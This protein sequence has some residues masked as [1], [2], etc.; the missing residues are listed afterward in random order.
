[1][2]TATRLPTEAKLL[3]ALRAGPASANDLAQTAGVNRKTVANRLRELRDQVQRLDDG[4]WQLATPGAVPIAHDPG[5]A[6]VRAAPEV[7]PPSAPAWEQRLTRLFDATGP[8]LARVLPLT[9]ALEAAAAAVDR[10][11]AHHAAL[12]DEIGVM[13]TE[14]AALEARHTRMARAGASDADLDVID[15]ALAGLSVRAGRRIAALP[16]AIRAHGAA[17]LAFC[18]TLRD[19]MT[20]VTDHCKERLRPTDEAW[21]HVSRRAAALA[22]APAHP[23]TRQRLS[24]DQQELATLRTVR[25][26]DVAAIDVLDAAWWMLP[27]HVQSATHLATLP[28]SAVA[29]WVTACERLPDDLAELAQ[30]RRTATG[31][32]DAIPV[33]KLERQLAVTRGL[34]V[35]EQ[36][37]AAVAS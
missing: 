30:L 26:D 6:R 1:M 17:R 5:E 33:R 3:A 14:R 22:E 25:Q 4:R 27:L 2:T 24:A 28:E 32:L 21:R 19:T 12:A 23:D 31:A 10:A 29:D 35:D 15:T 18:A 8:A 34:P 16:I 36:T 9:P 11:A 13:A 37:T 20:M 7:P